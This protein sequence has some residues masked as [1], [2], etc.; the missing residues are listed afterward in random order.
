MDSYAYRSNLRNQDPV[1][2]IF[3]AGLMMAICFW[4]KLPAISLIIFVIMSGFTV[5]RGKIPLAAYI[6]A[7]MVPLS[8]FLV[9]A[10]TLLVDKAG[11]RELFF[12]AIPFGNGYVGLIKGSS[13]LVIQ[14]L[15]QAISLVSCLFYLSFNTPMIDLLGG[16]RRL[17]V[18]PLVIELLGLIYR[19]IFIIL[20]EAH[21]IFIAQRSRLGYSSYR[22]GLRSLGSLVATLFI[23][24]YRRFDHLYTALES[25][26]YEGVLNVLEEQREVNKRGFL[27]PLFW[28]GILVI[29]TIWIRSAF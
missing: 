4:A 5:C 27:P 21:I 16:F 11:A 9:G 22:T 24:S 14:L 6:K 25:R 26:G 28:G 3:F 20:A 8:F 2:K 18:P 19:F 23:R 12:L 17:K 15:A 29:L 10:I 7:L 1:E 13:L